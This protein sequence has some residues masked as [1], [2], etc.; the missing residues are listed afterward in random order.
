MDLRV[1]FSRN[2]NLASL[3]AGSAF[4]VTA[5]PPGGTAREISGTSAAVN[6]IG[7]T[8]GVTL[9][10][11]V[12]AGETVTVS[13]A[14]P[15][16]NPLQSAHGTDV[17]DFSGKGV[18]NRTGQT[19]W[20]PLPVAG[21][22]VSNQ[23]QASAAM[24]NMDADVAQRFT[25][26]SNAAGYRLTG[27]DLALQAGT[28]SPAFTVTVEHDTDGVIG[29]LVNPAAII[30]G[31]DF[32]RAPGAG[33]DLEPNEAYRVVFDVTTP[34]ATARIWGTTA[35]AEDAGA[36]AEWSIDND[37]RQRAHGA[38]TWQS[39]AGKLKLS[40]HGY[41]KPLPHTRAV[42]D[43]DALTL[44]YDQGLDPASAPAGSAFSV[45]A[46]PPGGAART[47]AGTGTAT[48]SGAL[49]GETPTVIV[50]LAS[51]VRHGERVTVSYAKPA[52]DPLKYADGTDAAEISGQPAVNRTPAPRLSASV[53]GALLKVT[54]DESLDTGSAPASSAF[55]V[56]VTPPVGAAR[57]I[58]GSSAAVAIS[59][60][61]ASVTLASAVAEGEAVTVAYTK[62]DSNPLRYG[63]GSDVPVFSD[64]RV[65]NVTVDESPSPAVGLVS[66]T[67]QTNVGGG[68]LGFDRDTA[69]GFRTGSYA[70]GYRLTRVDIPV[71]HTGALPGYSVSIRSGS[72]TGTNLGTLTNPATL[73]ANGTAQFNA[74]G[75]GIQL[76]ADTNYW[77]LIDVNTATTSTLIPFT[78]SLQEDSGGEAGW[79]I[80][81]VIRSR[82][83]VGTGTWSDIAN[84]ALQLAIYGSANPPAPAFL[85]ATADGTAL[86]VTFDKSLKTD[87]LPAS[88]AFTATVTASDGTVRTIQGS[89]AAVTVDGATA[90]ATLSSAVAD[91]E[92]V[93]VSYARPSSNPLLSA[94]GGPV[95]DFSGETVDNLTGDTT[96]PS[97]ES[98]VANGRTVTYTFDEVLDWTVQL[99]ATD[100]L[101]QRTGVDDS[102][103]SAQA[104][105]LSG[106]TVTAT[107]REPARHGEAVMT[108]Y[109]STSN[110]ISDRAGN[111]LQD[112]NSRTATNHTPPAFTGASV[113]GR[114][115]TIAFDGDLAADAAS[116]PAAGDFAVE[117]NGRA[118]PLAGANPVAVAGSAVTLT[119]ARAARPAG[120]VTVGY[121]PGAKPL[122]DSDGGN[123]PVP[124]F[125]NR[126]ASN[127]TAGGP[128]ID[129]V[130]IVSWPSFDADGVAP[131]DT[132]LRG[133]EILVDVEFSEAVRITG[134]G[135]VR[136]RLQ[137]G[138]NRR[139]LGTTGSNTA[140]PELLHGGRT[141]R[142]LHRVQPGDTDTDGVLVF[143]G[144][145]N[146]ITQPHDD[147]KVVSAATGAAAVVTRGAATIM[148]T[149]DDPHHKVN[150]T[151]TGGSDVGPR[152]TDAFLNGKVMAVHF[153]KNV[154]TSGLADLK[155][156]FHVQGM[157]GIGG[158]S[159]ASRGNA[160]NPTR[161][162]RA[163]GSSNVLRLEFGLSARTDEPVT[164]TYG[165]TALKA[166]GAAGG[167]R[168]PR[169]RDFPVTNNTPGA[170]GPAP[171]RA[172]VTERTLRVTFDGDLDAAS[173]PPGSAFRVSTSGPDDRGRAIAGTGRAAVAG[174]VVTVTLAGAVDADEL[175]RVTY[176]RPETGW[177]RGAGAGKPV[178]LSFDRFTVESVDEGVAPKLA[179]GG[180]D[181]E[182]VRRCGVSRMSNSPQRSR[183]LLTFDE[184][185]VASP[186]PATG[187]FAVTKGTGNTAV[188]VSAVAVQDRSVVLT[189]NTSAPAGTAFNV[190]YTPPG[191]NP[192]RD[193]AGNAALSF[194]QELTATTAGT[195]ALIT[196]ATATEDERPSVDGVRVTLTYDRLLDPAQV[197]AASAYTLHYTL[198]TGET[199]ADRTT[200]SH[201]VASVGVEGATAVLHLDNPVF[202]CSPAFTV[203]YERPT[204]AGA[205]PLRGLQGRTADEVGAFTHQK[206][207]HP[208]ADRNCSTGWLQAATV[209]SVILTAV[210]PFATDEAPEPGW[211]AVTASGGPVTVTGAAF[212]A[213]DPRRLKLTLDREFGTSERVTVSY[214]RPAGE[215]GLWDADGNQLADIVDAPVANDGRAPAG[216]ALTASFEGMPAEH[217]GRGSAFEFE[218]RFS[219]NFP[220]RFDYRILK[221]HAF[222]VANGR[223]TGAKRVAK[224]RNDRW[225]VTVRPRGPGDVTVTLAAT[226][227]CA[228]AGA[229]CAPDGRKLSGTVS[230]TVAERA[231]SA[232]TG[233]P[234]IAGAARVGVTLT[235]SVGG[236]ADADGLDDA[237]FTFQ[238]ISRGSGG[239]AA[240]IAGAT[241]SSYTLTGAEEGRR[242]WVRVTFTDDAG[243][244]ESLA[245]AATAA[246]LPPLPPLTASF[247]GLPEEHDGKKPFEFELRF[248]ENF[249]GRFDYRILRDHAFTVTN[250]RVR[251]AQR[252]A[253]GRNDRWT[254]RVKPESHEDVVITLP[255]TTDC[256][257][258]GA[259][260]TPDGRMLSGA[261]TATVRGP[262]TLSVADAEITE[263]PD[264]IILFR[265]TLSRAVRETVTFDYET[266]DGTAVAGE[267]YRAKSGTATLHPGQTV[268]GL[269]V[270][271]LD[272]ALDEGSET[273]TVRI[274][275]ARGAGIVRAAATGTIKNDDP[276]QKMW[277]SRFGRTVASHVTEAVSDRL[278]N[279]LKGGQVTVAG[280]TVNLAETQDEAWLGNTLTSIARAMGAPSGPAAGGDPWPNTGPGAPGPGSPG[281]VSPGSGPGQAGTGG[282][283]G[284]GFGTRESPAGAGTPGRIP[285]GR[286][287]LLGSAFHLAK[288]GDGAT[289]GLAAWGRVA[290][291]GFDGAAPAD[292]GTDVR[293]DGTVTTGILGADAEWN[294]LLA[295]VAVS[296]SEGE[297]TFNQPGVDSGTIE[298]T[299]TTVS[300]YA[301]FMVNDRVSVWGLAGWG[302]GDM[303][304]VQ[305][306]NDRGQPE[307][308]T[309]TDLEMRLAALGGRGVLMEAEE[310]GFVDLALKADAFHVETESAPISNEGAT[311]GRANRL[312]LILEGS[313]AFDLGEGAVLTPGLELGL[314]HDGGDAETGTGVEL[315][316]SLRYADPGTGL[317]VEAQARML[318]AHADSDYEEWG[319]SGS[320]RLAPGERGR[321]LSFSLSPTLGAAGS[322]TERLWGAHR[323]ADLAP[324]GAGFEAAR[325]LQGELGY[326]LSVFGD[327]FTG[328][329]HLGFGLSDSAREYRIGWRLTS[330][331]RGDPRFQVDLDALRREAAN[332]NAPPEHGVM[333]R[334]M[335]RW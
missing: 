241:A 172:S 310:T 101:R 144:G 51:A 97:V 120:R 283:P 23:G 314:R 116:V 126:P 328:T 188:A 153:D 326:G 217:G 83:D 6:V 226:A 321:G 3:P 66:N 333:L 44:R 168:A 148:R 317:S 307:R 300:P 229:V 280:Q 43:G 60:A 12:A 166:T 195:P 320:V 45:M 268:I 74:P 24:L 240:E 114:T 158:S 156:D 22:L 30:S 185:L 312:R 243:N 202:P 176:V 309:R 75:D 125:S 206:V 274:S 40:V 184:A 187:S 257:A 124:G 302:T 91:G 203:S 315:G 255:A 151:K 96:A 32:F 244:A 108:W 118:A 41:A 162:S 105:V 316:G 261:A 254:I 258:A 281:S 49:A 180:G 169:F 136:L 210:R 196:A 99:Q 220:G 115:L 119:L 327:R 292:G 256:A 177:L 21:A 107:F 308:V 20:V 171:L 38:T 117:V 57:T 80:A 106:R 251:A 88:S 11:A 134:G 59:G 128:T 324:N 313:R 242:V 70:H 298:S 294:R 223:V 266:A 318:I 39:N 104:V 42:V 197:P 232:A 161:V 10:S 63:D 228:A 90:T 198:G 76:D 9:A 325:G 36:A 7:R 112:L 64:R 332:G 18:W 68:S 295:G 221:D 61:T 95:Q 182:P 227:D 230:A 225:T 17:A 262:A 152:V 322:G 129:R 29:T 209:G 157:A 189:L 58:Q 65:S 205:R 284:T 290:V 239:T 207:L 69:Q 79:S 54:F 191:T 143:T 277:L 247:H 238:W 4:T 259:I 306:A 319:A 155:F 113:D 87:A 1:A 48:V 130:R 111:D 47:I 335:V 28:G 235:A 150:G 331:V 282:W 263:G 201:R 199:A 67:G 123:E 204:G 299:M 2:L 34:D 78:P 33:I 287:L 5:T 264:A 190:A 31:A 159:A 167:R 208:R 100:F 110:R 92:A 127:V 15:D 26:G 72:E 330:A 37:R 212:D 62:P 25:T 267:D 154:A 142:F 103:I 19:P 237:T 85:N 305:A 271:I 224:G 56:S 186:A 46:T 303:T 94:A 334:G 291:G 165:G 183:M 218:L 252:V 14:K 109:G 249:P 164:L 131:D 245:S 215:A 253:K 272:D 146:I 222:E 193:A 329:P 296:V 213:A 175:A 173:L 278:A 98:I 269:L 89:S 13:Y 84:F 140:L 163:S 141:L 285:E 73:P 145:N 52:S 55:T 211:F 260:C 297:G 200:Y 160:V 275:N 289:P 181:G 71:T 288:E 179:C 147:Q 265:V 293:I 149:T 286:E 214:T 174:A 301:R 276:L 170:A 233:A 35:N 273:F 139:V 16:S 81:N 194:T 178:V 77:V 192:L 50:T 122:K 137:V 93:T 27:V 304:I 236:I 138:S 250:G 311:V 82:S 135:S 53:D 231:N 132:Y 219:E 102:A 121:A 270:D 216:P 234:K 133:D 248:S 86:K 279:P 246:V 323:A 8:V